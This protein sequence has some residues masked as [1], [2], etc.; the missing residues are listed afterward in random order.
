MP[1]I[2]VARD[3]GQHLH[4]KFVIQILKIFNLWINKGLLIIAVP[5]CVINVLCSVYLTNSWHHIFGEHGGQFHNVW[6]VVGDH[7][8]SLSRIQQWK[9]VFHVHSVHSAYRVLNDTQ[10][11]QRIQYCNDIIAKKNTNHDHLHPSLH[12]VIKQGVVSVVSVSSHSYIIDP[13]LPWFPPFPPLPQHH[14]HRMTH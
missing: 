14:Y 9:V 4:F 7:S 12:P 5:Q 6:V 13:M 2:S 10:Y 1:R 3:L 8:A 11:R